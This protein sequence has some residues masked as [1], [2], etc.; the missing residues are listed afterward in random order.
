MG[1]IKYPMVAIFK[2]MSDNGPPVLSDLNSF[3]RVGSCIHSSHH[4]LITAHGS[5]YEAACVHLSVETQ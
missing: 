3:Y 2:L 4:N 5:S 1:K